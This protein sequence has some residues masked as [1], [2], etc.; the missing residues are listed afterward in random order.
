[1]SA[2]LR[3][4][5]LTLLRAGPWLAIAGLCVL[6][7]CAARDYT[8][9]F[10][11]GSIAAH[12]RDLM[13]ITLGLLLFVFVPVVVLTLFFVWHYRAS[14][15]QA[16]YRPGWGHS[17]ILELFLWGGPIVIIIILGVL[18][19]YSTHQLDPY[20]PLAAADDRPTLQIDAIGLDW[21]WLFVYPD[22]GVASV[23]EIALPVNR[24]VRLR[25]TSDT[26]MMGFM[27]PALGSQ[28]MVMSGMQTR[29]HLDANQP[30]SYFGKNY[31]YSGDGFADEQFQ[32]IVLSQNGF[33]AWI[34]RVR[35]TGQ[36]LDADRYTTLARPSHDHRIEYF[37]PVQADLFDDVIGL[38]HR[39][40]PRDQLTLLEPRP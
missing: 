24:P 37:A 16:D 17:T 27:I 38:Y 34:E 1:M 15:T 30:G 13:L 19:W 7:G 35:S 25:L 22:Y 40:Q 4:I 31:Q 20:R 5:H 11:A 6:A 12:E 18:T 36:P 14:N 3:N 39:G 23:N 33:D 32:A 2:G 8:A 28:I 26:V 21:K 9:F 29:L 10:P